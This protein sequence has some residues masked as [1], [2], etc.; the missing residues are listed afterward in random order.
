[1]NI[2]ALK[3][4]IINEIESTT[5]EKIVWAMAHFLHLDDEIP[6]WQKEELTAR[7]KNYYSDE[8]NVMPVK[9]MEE[10]YNKK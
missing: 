3:K 2:A 10:K 6:D 7:L 8:T 5:D 1:M 9:E 4:E